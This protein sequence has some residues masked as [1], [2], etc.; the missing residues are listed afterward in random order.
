VVKPLKRKVFVGTFRHVVDDK[1]R[2]AIPSEWRS[3]KGSPEFYIL[4]HP[5][6]YLM[7]MPTDAMNTLMERAD[8]VSIGE[9]ERGD[10]LRHMAGG[11]RGSRCDKQGRINLTE[12]LLK[13]A[14]IEKE[15]VLV[16]IFTKF[17][18]WSPQRFEEV[19]QSTKEIFA[20]A[21][22]KLGL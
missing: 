20:E 6:N 21:A 14:G 2:V 10:V 9:Y 12:D 17:E 5:K 4:P 7:A 1:N 3:A 22:K 19:H 16:G 18:I 15:V 11:A 13:H 8:G